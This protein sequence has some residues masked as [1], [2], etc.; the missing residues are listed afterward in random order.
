MR[1]RLLHLTAIWL[2]VLPGVAMAAPSQDSAKGRGTNFFGQKFS[3][4]ATSTPT[5]FDADGTVQ[6]E[7]SSGGGLVTV[8]GEVTCLRVIADPTG[9]AIAAIEGRIT[10]SRPNTNFVNQFSSFFG[11]IS[12]SGK[13]STQA[14]TATFFI[15]TAPPPPDGGCS[16]PTVGNPISSGQVV[17]ENAV[18]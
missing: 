17:I 6:F 9:T 13:F 14:D 12:D 3:F 16:A 2:V 15:S 8:L 4:S 1:R 11:R 10:G 7:T 18:P 5:G